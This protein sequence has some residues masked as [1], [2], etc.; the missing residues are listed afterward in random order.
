MSKSMSDVKNFA[1]FAS[2]K[3]GIKKIPEIIFVHHEND[4][5]SSFGS[6]C[7]VQDNITVRTIDRHPL[8]VMRTVAHELVH[9][10]QRLD[11]KELDG[12]TGS[13]SENEASMKAS[14]IMRAYAS[15]NP[16]TFKYKPIKEDGGLGPSHVNSMG[17]SSSTSGT[18]GI[19]T[20]D[21]LMKGKKKLRSIIKRTPI[22]SIK[23]DT[24]L[25]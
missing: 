23:N 20:Y 3:L 6:Y 17:T 18:G 19:D 2:D 8:D 21:P 9:H 4:K 16:K 13:E 25:Y 11:G 10:K 12:A 14:E 24:K 22:E 15:S 7:P 5:K 1:K